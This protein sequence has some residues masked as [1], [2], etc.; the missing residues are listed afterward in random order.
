MHSRQVVALQFYVWEVVVL[1]SAQRPAF[2]TDSCGGSPQFL[3]VNAAVV[4][5]LYLPTSLP[6]IFIVTLPFDAI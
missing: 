6:D 1:I 4:V 3:H 5:A 2:L